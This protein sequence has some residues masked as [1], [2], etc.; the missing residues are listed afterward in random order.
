MGIGLELCVLC[1]RG[2]AAHTAMELHAWPSLNRT[3][4]MACINLVDPQIEVS[5]ATGMLTLAKG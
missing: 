1:S 2:Y 5:V 4:E 3:A